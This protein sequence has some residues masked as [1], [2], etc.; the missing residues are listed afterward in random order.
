MAALFRNIKTKEKT[1][2]KRQREM[3]KNI[4]DK[5]EK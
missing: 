3:Q 4:Q 5:T 1:R 2:G